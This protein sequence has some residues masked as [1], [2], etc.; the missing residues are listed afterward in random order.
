MTLRAR[1]L[2]ALLTMILLAAGV[3][4]RLSA[5]AQ[6]A[7]AAQ[8]LAGSIPA[9]KI[10]PG[11]IALRREAQAQTPLDKVGR[12]FALIGFE[13]GGFE[14]WAYPLK[15]F[16]G[17]ELSFL[18]G[19]STVAIEGRD[20][21]RFVSVDPAVTTLTFTYQSFT[22]KAHIV[23]PADDPGGSVHERGVRSRFRPKS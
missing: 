13:G 23:A 21:V 17:L 5:A 22:V 19:T 3:P 6:N 14:A 1:G 15:L 4:G 12:R 10:E 9:F 2:A 7:E 11:E 20:I 8:V 18:L 16:R